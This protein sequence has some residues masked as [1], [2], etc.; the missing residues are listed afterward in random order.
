M[1]EAA[2]QI[3][4][5]GAIGAMASTRVQLTN[6]NHNHYAGI[7]RYGVEA[8]MAAEAE[9]DESSGDDSVIGSLVDVKD[10]DD[11]DDT[12]VQDENEPN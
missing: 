4:L 12:D 3:L 2:M 10:Y 8:A 9:A 11:T 1:S 5:L 7:H 6:P